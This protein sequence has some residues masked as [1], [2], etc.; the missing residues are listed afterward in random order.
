MKV[1]WSFRKTICIVF[2]KETEKESLDDCLLDSK[3]QFLLAHY[4]AKNVAYKKPILVV[5]GT[6]L[7]FS[8]KF[9]VLAYV[10]LV[11]T[12]SGLLDMTMQSV[13]CPTLEDT[14]LM[15]SETYIV[16]SAS[17]H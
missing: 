2:L 3:I 15:K 1:N 7:L 14:I 9:I 17:Q 13:N 10:M 12:L 4:V 11:L 5:D 16:T 6:F 8:Y